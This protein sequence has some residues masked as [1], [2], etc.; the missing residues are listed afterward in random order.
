MKHGVSQEAMD[1]YIK[2]SSRRQNHLFFSTNSIKNL[3]RS[4]LSL[5]AFI[6]FWFLKM[7]RNKSGRTNTI[8][9]RK[10]R[11]NDKGNTFDH[12]ESI[13]EPIYVEPLSSAPPI[14]LM[15]YTTSEDEV[16]ATNASR[17]KENSPIKSINT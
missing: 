3:Q 8:K 6:F 5:Q 9:L 2:E 12:E 17:Q 13:M 15:P 4:K 14:A 7:V 1:L 11:S 16:P 10:G